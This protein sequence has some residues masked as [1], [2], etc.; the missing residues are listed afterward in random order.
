M[1]IMAE[2]TDTINLS[3]SVNIG[4]VVTGSEKAK[5]DL[6]N[7]DNSVNKKRKVK[8]DVE[9]NEKSQEK[10][11]KA[12]DQSLVACKI[13]STPGINSPARYERNAYPSPPAAPAPS[14]SA[15][16]QSKLSLV[17]SA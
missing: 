15:K 13:I 9:V 7:I 11:Q 12:I 3:G 1:K 2:H 4:V 14:Q 10:A 16:S 17:T 8:I 5:N 6:N